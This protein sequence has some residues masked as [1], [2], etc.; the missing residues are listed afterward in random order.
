MLRAALA[1]ASRGWAVIPA[2][3]VSPRGRCT[4]GSPSCASPAKHPLTRHGLQDATTDPSMIR[5]WWGQW[6]RANV[7]VRTGVESGLVVL[8][9]DL[10]DGFAS[11]RRL[12]GRHAPLGRSLV[13]RTGSG[14]VHLFLAHPGDNVA[15]SNRAS[16]V[17]GPGLDVRGDGGYVIAPPSRHVLGGTYRWRM[18]GPPQAM[19]DWLVETLAP[20]RPAEPQRLSPR[21]LVRGG[22]RACA[23]AAVALDRETEAVRRSPEGLRNHTLNRA[24]FVLGQIVGGGHLERDHVASLLGQ[25]GED[26]GLASREIGRT[27][28]SGLTAGMRSPRH[29]PARLDL[30]TVALDAPA[31][32]TERV[33]SIDR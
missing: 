30:R 23:W 28:T 15:I 1:Y 12:E 22:P 2:H 10:P 3:G 33:H 8:D 25:A 21:T 4:C 7:A 5:R 27:I 9:I 20:R 11:L 29:P 19:P 26:A 24:A 31:Q 13:A 18:D 14:G 16:S 17:L 32:P 6:P